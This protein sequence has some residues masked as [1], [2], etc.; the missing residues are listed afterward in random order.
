ME[1]GF[2]APFVSFATVVEIRFCVFCAFLRPKKQKALPG[3]RQRLECVSGG[4]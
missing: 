3:D 1:A 4:Q 2:S